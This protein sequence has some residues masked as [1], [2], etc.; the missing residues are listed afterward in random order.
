M[1]QHLTALQAA[2]AVCSA[3]VTGAEVGSSEITF[4]PGSVK[5]GDYQFAIGTAGSTTR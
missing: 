1:R 4:R 2:A 5:A 3:S